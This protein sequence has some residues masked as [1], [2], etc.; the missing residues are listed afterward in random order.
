MVTGTSRL[1]VTSI[2]T[3]GSLRGCTASPAALHPPSWAGWTQETENR[4][5]SSVGGKLPSLHI[6]WFLRH[7]MGR[8]NSA[9][10]WSWARGNQPPKWL[11]ATSSHS[12][13]L[14]LAQGLALALGFKLRGKQEF[15]RFQNCDS[16]NEGEQQPIPRRPPNQE[17]K[18]RFLHIPT[19][20]KQW[21][22]SRGLGRPRSLQRPLH[23]PTVTHQ[24]A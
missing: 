12:H 19:T 16:M 22:L 14:H 10:L 5:P 13:P 15:Y 6:H 3:Q 21:R 7:L 17:G 8:A 9:E 23:T 11:F 2:Q 4:L 18:D 1:R 24:C 20:Q